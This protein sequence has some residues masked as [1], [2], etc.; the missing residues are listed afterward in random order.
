[1]PDVSIHAHD[2]SI[3]PFNSGRKMAH[4]SIHASHVS[5]HGSPNLSGP[6]LSLLIDT[7]L[8]GSIDVSIHDL[9]CIDTWTFLYRYTLL[10]RYMYRYRNFVYRYIK[11]QN[12]ETSILIITFSY[13]LQLR[14]FKLCWIRN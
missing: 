1:M 9:S 11:A 14:R 10:D 5:I 13:E 6:F 8:F 3:H 2:V 4:V 7:Y 12:W